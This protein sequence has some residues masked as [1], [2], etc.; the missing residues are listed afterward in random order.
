MG[1]SEI[2]DVNYVIYSPLPSPPTALRNIP[3]I[4]NVTEKY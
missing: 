4:E 1:I 2:A 3:A